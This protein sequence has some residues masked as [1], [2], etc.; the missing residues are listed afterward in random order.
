MAVSRFGVKVSFLILSEEAGG[1]AQVKCRTC[2]ELL[3]C[4]CV[5]ML[6]S[7]RSGNLRVVRHQLLSPDSYRRPRLRHVHGWRP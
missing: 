5:E 1:T 6:I 2:M 7:G 4:E 3:L